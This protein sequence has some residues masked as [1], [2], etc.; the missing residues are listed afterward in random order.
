MPNGTVDLTAVATDTGGRTATST[1]VPV[2]VDN[3][4]PPSSDRVI[5]I[6]I[7]G[8]N[9]E[10]LGQTATPSLDRMVDEG[11]STENARTAFES[12]RPCPTTCRW[13]PASRS[14]RP[15]ATG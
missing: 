8:F 14:P 13:S 11:V 12:T 2:T 6:T 10:A 4:P 5:V 1:T 7:D 9:P 3:G 15:V